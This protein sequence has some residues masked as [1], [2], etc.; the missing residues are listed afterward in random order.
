M[1]AY[2]NIITDLSAF[3]QRYQKYMRK[4]FISKFMTTLTQY[5]CG[6]RKRYSTQ[7]CLLY[8]LEYLRKAFDKGMHTGI[9]LTDLTKAF[10]S[11][12]FLLQS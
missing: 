11:M 12:I 5:L 7:H 9:L 10:D 1:T 8:M 4:F 3:Y 2:S 6:F